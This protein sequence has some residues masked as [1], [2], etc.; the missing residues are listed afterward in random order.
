MRNKLCCVL[1]YLN[2]FPEACTD[3]NGMQV[4]MKALKCAS[5]NAGGKLIYAS[6]LVTFFVQNW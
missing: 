3:I 4:S 2:I 1:H 5:Y 6:V